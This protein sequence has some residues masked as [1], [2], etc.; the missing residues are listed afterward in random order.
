MDAAASTTEEM[1]DG[2]HRMQ[3][4][5]ARVV[6]HIAVQ[7]DLNPT[8]LRVLKYLG[9]DADVSVAKTPGSVGAYLEMSRGAVT[10]LLDRL[11]ARALLR[12]AP[13]P[14]DRRGT[15][16]SLTDAGASVVDRL[17]ESYANAIEA[18]VPDELRSAFL[19]G[20][21]A[22]GRALDEQVTADIARR[23]RS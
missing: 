19:Q 23:A 16:L 15:L 2:F 12:R 10:A 6:Q 22:L 17:R 14:H 7:H 5:H 4:E 9:I 1:V 13:N 3:V 18:S 11:E 8:D 21:R 20:C